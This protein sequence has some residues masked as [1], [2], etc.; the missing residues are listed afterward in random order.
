M[1][2]MTRPGGIHILYVVLL[3]NKSVHVSSKVPELW[4]LEVAIGRNAIFHIFGRK[5]WKMLIFI[6][7]TTYRMWMPPGRVI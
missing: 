6:N 2:Q 7:E 5:I 4:L 1:A 3:I